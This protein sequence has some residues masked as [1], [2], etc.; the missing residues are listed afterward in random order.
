[1]VL[2][3]QPGEKKH[4]SVLV[5]MFLRDQSLKSIFRVDQHSS[6]HQLP[7][8]KSRGLQEREMRLYFLVLYLVLIAATTGNHIPFPITKI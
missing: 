7:D 2:S 4:I 8:L 6:N 1:M 5:Q 3:F